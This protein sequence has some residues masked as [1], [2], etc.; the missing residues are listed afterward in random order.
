MISYII[1]YSLSELLSY[2]HRFSVFICFLFCFVSSIFNQH[3]SFHRFFDLAILHV[4]RPLAMLCL[5]L[6]LLI[7][8]CFANDEI[9]NDEVRWF[10]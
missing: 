4:E 2:F 1:F 7:P 8:L 9:S 3:N 5:V 10:D 6:L